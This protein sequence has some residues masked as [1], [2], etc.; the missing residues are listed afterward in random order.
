MTFLDNLI[1]GEYSSGRMNLNKRDILTGFII[2]LVI[3]IGVFSF[4]K[5]K[6][7]SSKNIATSSPVSISFKEDLEESFK[8]KIPDNVKYIDL[9][10]VSGGTGK[11]VA[12][13]S[14]ILA[15]LDDPQTGYFYQAWLVNGEDKL[16]LGKMAVAKGGWLL[17]YNRNNH[18]GY[19]N[20]VVSLEKVFDSKVEKKIL[21]GSF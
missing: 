11:A 2:V 15:D 13:D 20:I 14:E 16:S 9:K 1:G 6:S 8:Y 5:I 10:D 3:I 12:T 19:K 7:K 18:P 17:E 21:E 4:N